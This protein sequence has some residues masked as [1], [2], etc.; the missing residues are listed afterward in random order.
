MVIG[1]ADQKHS[2]EAKRL[3]ITQNQQEQISNN[4]NIN[5]HHNSDDEEE[6]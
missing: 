5:N 1:F 6:E 3:R 2:D 4:M